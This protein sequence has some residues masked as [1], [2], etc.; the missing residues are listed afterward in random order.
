MEKENVFDKQHAN[1]FDIA[2]NVHLEDGSKL[3]QLCCLKQTCLPTG[4]ARKY[5]TTRL[6]L[7]CFSW[8]TQEARGTQRNTQGVWPCKL[9]T[10]SL[11]L[12]QLA[13]SPAHSTV[14][15][16]LPIFPNLSYKVEE[17]TK[18]SKR[19]VSQELGWYVIE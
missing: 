14:T 15:N 18:K 3:W 4:A 2:A 9:P 11:P 8:I 1:W 13:L 7:M 12:Q 17:K 5:L 16:N 10:D 6:S 19:I